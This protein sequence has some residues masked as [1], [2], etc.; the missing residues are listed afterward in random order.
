MT[1]EFK[2]ES[3]TGHAW[4]RHH[5]PRMVTLVCGSLGYVLEPKEALDLAQELVA[6][7]HYAMGYD[8]E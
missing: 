5:P 2:A 6:A 8:K 1:V 3:Y 4:A 7:A